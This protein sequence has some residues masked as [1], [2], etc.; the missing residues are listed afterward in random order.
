MKN[1]TIRYAI[2]TNIQRLMLTTEDVR[3]ET[4]LA[5]RSC[6][7]QSALQAILCGAT[8]VDVDT[9][10]AI[11]NALGVDASALVADPELPVD[12]LTLYRSR[13]AALPAD[14]QQRIQEFIDSVSAA[15][16]EPAVH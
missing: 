7:L 14:Q 12:P 4:E 10:A 9:L 3:T 2:A 1:S 13:I 16:E 15:H 5:V 6:I 11:A 8:D